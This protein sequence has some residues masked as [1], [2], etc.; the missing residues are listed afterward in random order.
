MNTIPMLFDQAPNGLRYPRVGGRGKCLRCRKKPKP[1]KYSK[2]AQNPTRRVHALLGVF[3]EQDSLAEK[4]NT[5]NMPNFI[6]NINEMEHQYKRLRA[7]FY[8]SILILQ[9]LEYGL[10]FAIS[11]RQCC[12][13]LGN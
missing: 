10:R 3:F 13:L 9:L 2:I 12:S 6:P 11:C 4:D 7:I 5:A 1:E 8:P